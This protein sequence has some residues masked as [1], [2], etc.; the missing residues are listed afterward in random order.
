M[1]TN[2]HKR[3]YSHISDT[4]VNRDVIQNQD[5]LAGLG[6]DDVRKAALPRF[7]WY[8]VKNFTPGSQFSWMPKFQFKFQYEMA[9]DSIVND[10]SIY[11]QSYAVN[12][13]IKTFSLVGS[14]DCAWPIME[15]SNISP[16]D[17]V[18]SRKDG[19]LHLTFHTFEKALIFLFRGKC[20]VGFYDSARLFSMTPIFIAM[21]EPLRKSADSFMV[22]I[23]P[24]VTLQK[25]I[26]HIVDNVMSI[27]FEKQS[28]LKMHV[29]HTRS[30]LGAMPPDFEFSAPYSPASAIIRVNPFDR[31][32]NVLLYSNAQKSR[33][34]FQGLLRLPLKNVLAL[35]GNTLG[36]EKNYMQHRSIIKHSKCH[37]DFRFVIL[38]MMDETDIF[39]DVD[40]DALW[41]IRT[42]LFYSEMG[43]WNLNFEDTL[44]DLVTF[45][46]NQPLTKSKF[47]LNTSSNPLNRLAQL[48]DG[49][50]KLQREIM[51]K[52]SMVMLKEVVDSQN[53]CT[54]D[55]NQLKEQFL[56]LERDYRNL[57]QQMTYDRTV[58]LLQ[59]SK[60]QQINAISMQHV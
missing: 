38:L 15:A 39:S 1:A 42:I 23:P 14:L 36:W 43:R 30:S 55:F 28:R 48:S 37:V 33:Y 6:D 59:N 51:G 20:R 12:T 10:L 18:L 8:Q 57:Q 45:I 44:G 54:N 25:A 32:N 40:S 5:N 56:S 52:P 3:K 7:N 31:R 13:H 35:S 41:T 11:D 19:N 22:T 21:F 34:D 27:R 26:L 46:R 49:I 16:S 53:K 58:I 47:L 17:Y 24:L 29:L 4:S 2:R 9:S 50:Y 60:I